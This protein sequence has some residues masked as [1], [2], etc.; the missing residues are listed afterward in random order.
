M[1]AVAAAVMTMVVVRETTVA[2]A[3]INVN[4]L[5]ID[6]LCPTVVALN[7]ILRSGL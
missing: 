3:S 7:L 2:A 5:D 6:L 1:A 4:I